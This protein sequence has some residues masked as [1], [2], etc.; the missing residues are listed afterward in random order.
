MKHSAFC[1]MSLVIFTLLCLTGIVGLKSGIGLD[2]GNLVQVAFA[3]AAVCYLY[4]V[5]SR[6]IVSRILGD[7]LAALLAMFSGPGLAVW[8]SS[9][10]TEAAAPSFWYGALIGVLFFVVAYVLNKVF[11]GRLR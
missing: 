3:C 2:F 1:L 9:K 4:N 5:A 7:D 8:L 6:F 10:F 11:S